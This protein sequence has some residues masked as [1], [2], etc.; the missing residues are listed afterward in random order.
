MAREDI[1]NDVKECSSPTCYLAEADPA[2][3]GLVLPAKD[4][5]NPRRTSSP[6]EP[7]PTS[8]AAE[9]KPASPDSANGAEGHG[10]P[11]SKTEE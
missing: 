7:A 11:A 10:E 6:P 2:Y 5:D 9:A 8:A 3:A 4:K 1:Q